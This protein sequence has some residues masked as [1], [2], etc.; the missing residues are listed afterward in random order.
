MLLLFSGDNAVR[1]TFQLAEEIA[2]FG[3]W[4][5][6]L[7]TGAMTCSDNMLRLLG[8]SSPPTAEGE[9]HRRLDVVPGV[10]VAAG[11]PRHHARGQLPLGDGIDGL[12]ELRGRDHAADV[13]EEGVAHVGSPGFRA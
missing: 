2:H 10:G 4:Q 13:A 7:A 11:E 6:D 3:L 9:G 5:V 1:D 12:P 8:L